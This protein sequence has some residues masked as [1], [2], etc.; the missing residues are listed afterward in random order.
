[1]GKRMDKEVMDPRDFYTEMVRIAFTEGPEMGHI[2]ADE[3]MCEI[4]TQLGY[5]DGIK[6]FEE[7]EKWYS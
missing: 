6:L 3:L 7:M 1:M 5:G 2:R 4:L